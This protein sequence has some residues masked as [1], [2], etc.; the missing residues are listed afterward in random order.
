VRRHIPPPAA[1]SPAA[2][3]P[4]A[5]SPARAKSLPH[6]FSPR[7]AARAI[8][9]RAPRPPPAPLIASSSCRLRRP[10][11]REARHPP[12]SSAAQGAVTA[13]ATAQ[14]T[15]TTITLKGSAKTVTEFFNIAVNKWAIA[16]APA[17]SAAPIARGGGP[18]AARRPPQHPLPARHLPARHL[19]AA[20]LPG[21]A[22]VA[23]QGHRALGLLRQHHAPDAGC[24]ARARPL[25]SRAP[26][27]QQQQ[28]PAITPA[29]AA[30]ARRRRRADWLA[31]GLLQKLVL[32]ITSAI[33]KEVLERWTF[34]IDTSKE[35]LGKG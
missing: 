34:E 9:A 12:T 16:P 15:K 29:R 24:A 2:A 4:A 7:R 23:V 18:D 1:A 27:A 17:P 30:A 32:V 35:V 26:A 31:Q 33:T 22:G 8:A 6:L 11:P 13:M 19:R 10:A 3:S 5:A 14:A 28:R 20:A 25:P 21:A